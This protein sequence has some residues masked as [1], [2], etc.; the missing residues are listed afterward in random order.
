M[1]D[2]DTVKEQFSQVFTD[3]DYDGSYHTPLAESARASFV[4]LTGG[5]IMWTQVHGD[6]KN[7]VKRGLFEPYPHWSELYRS[8]RA[9][10]E[11]HAALNT[12]F[13]GDV[14]RARIMGDAMALLRAKYGH[15][16]PKWWL[17]IMNQLRDSKNS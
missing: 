9:V 16:A 1:K 3:P 15:N 8:C 12:Q 5:I 14:T 7:V 17:R 2:R 10:V 11:A 6:F 4:E 13:S